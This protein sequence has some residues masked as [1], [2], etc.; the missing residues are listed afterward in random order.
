MPKPSS[1]AK[2]FVY[3]DAV[4][5]SKDKVW[6]GGGQGWGVGGGAGASGWG[7][8]GGRERRGFG[9]VELRALISLLAF[10]S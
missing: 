10:P 8:V 4:Y 1:R 5:T 7:G 6:G 9:A 2:E 3:L